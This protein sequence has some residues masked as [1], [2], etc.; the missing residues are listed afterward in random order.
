[1][2]HNTHLKLADLLAI[3]LLSFSSFSIN[4]EE[5]KEDPLMNKDQV[6]GRVEQS[7]GKIKEVT[8]NIIGDKQMEIQGNIQKNVGKAQAGFGD[9][10]EE[11]KKDK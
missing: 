1:M 8:G 2:T 5:T 10:K 11:I 3:I 4:A 9:L 6:E 7:K